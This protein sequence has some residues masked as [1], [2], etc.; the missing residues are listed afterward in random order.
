M[1]RPEEERGSRRTLTSACMICLC[2]SMR[3]CRSARSVP[4]KNESIAKLRAEDGTGSDETSLRQLGQ[5]WRRKNGAQ[6]N[7]ENPSSSYVLVLEPLV[8]AF[9]TKGMPTSE[10]VLRTRSELSSA[11]P[12]QHC[13]RTGSQKPSKQQEQKNSWDTRSF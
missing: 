12:R 11:K 10:R 9:Q 1:M 4:V 3:L 13:L 2:L 5:F 8:D 7:D 6:D